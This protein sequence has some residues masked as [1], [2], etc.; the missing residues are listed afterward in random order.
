MDR[1]PSVRALWV[2]DGEAAAPLLERI[3]RSR[4]RARHS[5]MG[6]LA[7]VRTG[8]AGMDVLALPS[9]GPETFG[10]A[11]IEAQ[12]LG[13]PVLASRHGGIPE[14]LEDGVTGLLLPAGDVPAWAEA[15]VRLSGDGAARARMG[16]AGRDFVETRFCQRRIA[17]RFEQLLQEDEPVS[18]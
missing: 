16:A 15:I 12:A 17:A 11:S 9:I 18:A 2:G 4:H 10:R 5:H 1:S 14:T 8:Y 13:L 6:W 3:W 7:D